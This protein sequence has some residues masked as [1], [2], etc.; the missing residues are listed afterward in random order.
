M[1]KGDIET[2]NRLATAANRYEKKGL[3]DQLKAAI[4]LGG[5][6]RAA[7][8]GATI[9][10][11]DVSPDDYAVLQEYSRSI[12]R[13]ILRGDRDYLKDIEHN[14]DALFPDSTGQRAVIK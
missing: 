2:L 12:D 3:L 7:E 1:L 14:L 6:T 9:N 13:A 4:A 8:S 11:L 5:K 10:P